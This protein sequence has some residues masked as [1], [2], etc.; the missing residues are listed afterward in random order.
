MV[1]AGGEGPPFDFWAYFDGIPPADFEGHGCSAGIIESVYRD[2]SGRHKHVRVESEDR[3]VFRV[4]VLG[5][6][7]GEV[8]GHRLLDLKREYGLE[9]GGRASAHL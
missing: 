9:G 1:P 4:L 7:G 2:R 8:H 6:L 3:N 5:L